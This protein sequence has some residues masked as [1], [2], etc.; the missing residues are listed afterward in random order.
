MEV[1]G[2][3]V[4]VLGGSSRRTLSTIC[5]SCRIQVTWA[6]FESR[7][8]AARTRVPQKS[9]QVRKY[10]EAVVAIVA[11]QEQEIRYPVPLSSSEDYEPPS[12]QGR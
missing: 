7:V 12:P 2:G 11:K 3:P 8:A 4:R 9:D 10:D 6:W 1:L 5:N